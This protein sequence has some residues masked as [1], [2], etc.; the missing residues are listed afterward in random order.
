MYVYA[1]DRPLYRLAQ[2]L[3]PL[4]QRKQNK[5]MADVSARRYGRKSRS[6]Y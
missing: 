5:Y 3:E 2:S 6:A 1:S 4:Q